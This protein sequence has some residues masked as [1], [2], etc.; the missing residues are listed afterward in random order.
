MKKRASDTFMLCMATYLERASLSIQMPEDMDV[1]NCQVKVV[2]IGFSLDFSQ[3]TV[4]AKPSTCGM[5]KLLVSKH[6]AHFE[7]PSIL[8][9]LP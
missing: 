4:L 5:T 8:D 6:V 1:K 9:H 7:G 2:I 3:I